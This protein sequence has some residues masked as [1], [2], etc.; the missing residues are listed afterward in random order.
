MGLDSL[1][2]MENG[3]LFLCSQN[4]NIQINSSN[5]EMNGILYAPNGYVMITGEKFTL[6]GRIIA[7]KI[8]FYGSNLNVVK[9]ENDLD[10]LDCLSDEVPEFIVDSLDLG[11]ANH[12]FEVSLTDGL[13]K[14]M[15]RKLI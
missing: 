15:I 3:S 5:I 13:K 6:N 2:T 11:R 8:L 12:V 14:L 10:I 9:G 7:K 1:N 4:G